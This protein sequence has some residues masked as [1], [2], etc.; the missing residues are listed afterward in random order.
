MI[1]NLYNLKQSKLVENTQSEATTYE[2]ELI[3]P[4]NDDANNEMFPNDISINDMAFIECFYGYCRTYLSNSYKDNTTV[5]VTS[6]KLMLSALP[7]ITSP[8]GSNITRTI[9]DLLI[10]GAYLVDNSYYNS[11]GIPDI[12]FGENHSSMALTPGTTFMGLQINNDRVI[13]DTL[14]SPNILIDRLSIDSSNTSARGD[15]GSSASGALISVNT[16]ELHDKWVN[17]GKDIYYDNNQLYHK[18]QINRIVRDEENRLCVVTSGEF[19]ETLLAGNQEYAL[20]GFVEDGKYLE[21]IESS[22]IAPNS[23]SIDKNDINNEKVVILVGGEFIEVDDFDLLTPLEI[24]L[25]ESGDIVITNKDDISKELKT[26]YDYFIGIVVKKSSVS[27]SD[28]MKN[29]TSTTER[30][31]NLFKYRNHRS[32]AGAAANNTINLDFHYAPF[33]TTTGIVTGLR[34]AIESSEEPADMSGTILPIGLYLYRV[35]KELSKTYTEYFNMDDNSWRGSLSKKCIHIVY[36][37]SVYASHN[38][39]ANYYL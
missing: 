23:L 21:I 31:Q 22:D 5:K 26:T 28:E 7:I 18:R 8:D 9:D 3:K 12:P 35:P 13:S 24:G 36:N 17:E 34:E 2:L 30:T 32:A 20:F 16:I 4:W 39:G 33:D 10:S 1:S 37:G 15:L 6:N 29:V 25:N 14:E 38:I 27:G 11:S 19:N